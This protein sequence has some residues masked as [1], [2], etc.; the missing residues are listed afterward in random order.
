MSRLTLDRQH[1]SLTPL[2]VVTAA[3]VVFTILLILVRLQWAPWESAD[4]DSAVRLNSLIAGHAALVAVVKA[5]T[6]LGSDGVLWT[7]IGASWRSGGG[8]G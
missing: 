7:V 2:I 5:V 1:R 8:G 6:W 3:A 4:H